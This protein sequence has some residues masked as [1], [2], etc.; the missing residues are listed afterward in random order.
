MQYAIAILWLLFT[1]HALHK[2][3]NEHYRG[4]PTG[5]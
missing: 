1:I 4:A 3:R 5:R 2:P